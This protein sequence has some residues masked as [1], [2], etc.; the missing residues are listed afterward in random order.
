MRVDSS[1]YGVDGGGTPALRFSRELTAHNV[2]FE[3]DYTANTGDY[4]SLKFTRRNVRVNLTYYK[5]RY[6]IGQE[7]DFSFSNKKQCIF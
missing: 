5:I 2:Y 1:R 7:E 3:K 6:F 4:R